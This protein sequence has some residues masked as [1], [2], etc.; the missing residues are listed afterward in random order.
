MKKI[1][2]GLFGFGTIG[3]GVAQVLEEN[4]EVISRRLGAELFLKKI[5]DLDIET[6]RGM[7][8]DRKILSTN[9][10]EILNDPEISIV[11]ELIGGTGA[12]KKV[13]EAALSAGKHVVTANKALLAIHGEELCKKARQQG[14]KICYEAS[15][16]GG[17]P[18]LRTLKEGL[19]A[20]RIESIYGIV[21]GTANY[22]LTKMTEEGEAFDKVLK[23]AMDRGYAEAD[24]TY[25]VEGIDS[26]HKLAILAS[27]AFGTPVPFDQVY[28]EGIS[29]ITPLDIEYARGFGYKIKLLGIT[30]ASDNSIEVRV[31]PTMIPE[32]TLLAQVNGVLNAIYVNGNAVGPT[33]YYGKG[34]GALPTASAVVGDL[35]EIA[36]DLLY[37]GVERVPL[38]SFPE[39]YRKPVVVRAMNEVR[40]RYFLRFSTADR[41]GVLSKISGILADFGISI[42]SVI[43][44]GRKSDGPVP[45]VMVTHMARERNVKEALARIDA[46]A[47]TEGETVLIRIEDQNG[48][49]E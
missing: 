16:G 44:T 49:E 45:I 29:R 31:H 14:V 2:I 22:I 18:I 20:N 24:P 38:E 21:N 9:S 25:D 26:A 35:M 37:G 27:L 28:T 19:P 23:E 43:Q 7:T 39:E 3:T 34:A 6:D 47:M 36:R 32:S 12:A 8:L 13:V 4:R 5:V 40:T 42:S 46:L 10:E 11:I 17:I 41:P 48:G 15:V 1:A 30:K 33:L